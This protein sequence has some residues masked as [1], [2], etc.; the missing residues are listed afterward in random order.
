MKFL[1]ALLLVPSALQA[2]VTAAPRSQYFTFE[3]RIKS[4]GLR[5]C[6]LDETYLNSLPEAKRFFHELLHEKVTN[7]L[8]NKDKI[9][10]MEEKIA[11]KQLL[12]ANDCLMQKNDYYAVQLLKDAAIYLDG[13]KQFLAYCY[14]YG[15][16]T[17]KKETTAKILLDLACDKEERKTID[18]TLQEFY[19]Q[20][21]LGL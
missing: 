6:D 5:Y 21:H 12:L 10:T 4:E 20:I 1:L 15:I 17:P 18:T 2:G 7:A 16:G 8:I 13:A 11:L 14:R 9:L 19:E 3:T